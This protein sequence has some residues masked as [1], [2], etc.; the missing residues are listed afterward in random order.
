MS[1]GAAGHSTLAHVEAR[2]CVPPPQADEIG[3]RAA[4][5]EQPVRTGRQ[6]KQ[7]DEPAD[8][9]ILHD[10]GRVVELGDLWVHS[11]GQHV[12]QHR[13]RRARADHPAPEAWVNVTRGV[14]QDIALELFVDGGGCGRLAGHRSRK[15]LA[16]LGGHVAPDGTLSR[17]AE[18]LEH[19]IHHLVA[20]HAQLLPPAR[21]GGVETHL[22]GDDQA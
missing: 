21:V 9:L 11:R 2:A 19:V 13:E 10:G 18:V 3:H 5:H 14:G 4:G 16:D 22:G 12:G 20:Q 15:P 6:A 8:H 1:R 17:R 7:L